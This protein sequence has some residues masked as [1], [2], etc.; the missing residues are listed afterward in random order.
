MDP[1]KHGSANGGRS[2]SSLKTVSEGAV[3]EGPPHKP[4]IVKV[5]STCCLL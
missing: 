4:Q 1:G 5:I 3:L 2:N